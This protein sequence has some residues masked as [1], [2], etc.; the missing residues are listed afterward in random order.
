LDLD[1]GLFGEVNALST[2]N[3]ESWIGATAVNNIRTLIGYTFWIALFWFIYDTL[4]RVF[5]RLTHQSHE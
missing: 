2:E 4:H 1:T 3:A 5:I